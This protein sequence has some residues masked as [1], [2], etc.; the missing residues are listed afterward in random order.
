MGIR[1]SR[2]ERYSEGKKCILVKTWGQV[3]RKGCVHNKI[4]SLIFYDIR[5]ITTIKSIKRLEEKIT[6]KKNSKKNK[7]QRIDNCPYRKRNY[8]RLILQSPLGPVIAFLVAQPIT[9][10]HVSSNFES[11]A[12]EV[13][14]KHDPWCTLPLPLMHG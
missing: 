9:K 2:F 10:H 12:Q 6:S 13:P 3:S 1:L 7:I 8:W 5:M 11:H 4:K 14:K